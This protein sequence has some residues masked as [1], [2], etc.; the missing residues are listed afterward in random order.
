MASSG[1]EAATF[2]AFYRHHEHAL[3]RHLQRTVRSPAV[4]AELAA[5]TFALA[6]REASAF[7]PSREAPAAWLFALADRVLL[8][9]AR[10]GRV[11]DG[12]RRALGID[13][14]FDDRALRRIDALRHNETLEHGKARR[15]GETLRRG[16]AQRGRETARRGQAPQRGEAR[17]LSRALGAQARGPGDALAQRQLVLPGLERALVGAARRREATH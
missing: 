2:A 17:P 5:E 15:G 7:D 14:R 9:R 1:T 8:R 10:T 4:T 16:E 12:A 11:D 6:L 3:I 13:L